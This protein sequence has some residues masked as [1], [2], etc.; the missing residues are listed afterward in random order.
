MA[1]KTRKSPSKTQTA[2]TGRSRAARRSAVVGVA[3]AIFITFAIITL[4]VYQNWPYLRHRPPF[5]WLNL[6]DDTASELRI[7]PLLAISDRPEQEPTIRF[8]DFMG[9]E[10]CAECHTSEYAAWRSSTHGTA[11][12]L[13]GKVGII[14]PFDGAPIRYRD[15]IV[16]P[17]RRDDSTY[18]FVLRRPGRPDREFTVAAVVGGGHMLGGGTQSFF[19]RFSDGTLR[20]LPFDFSK[21]SNTWFSQTR[22]SLH[23][24]PVQGNLALEDL[25]EWPPHRVLGIESTLVNCQNCHG[26]QIDLTFDPAA[27]R[28][29]T[30]FKS[31]AIDCET[32]HGPGRRHV[33]V[34]RSDRAAEQQDI[35]MHSLAALDKDRSLQVCFQCHAIKDVLQ[36]DYL[37]GRPL[38]RYFSFKMPMLAESPYHVDGRI[39]NFGYQ[40]NH[41]YSDCYLNGSMTC[42]DCHDP[43]SQKYRDIWG[44]PLPGKLDDAQCIDC[45]ASKARNLAAHTHHPAAS[46]GSRCVA[47]HMPFLQHPGI[48]NRVRF[49]RSDHT[50]AIPRPA[51][52]ASLGITGACQQCH[53]RVSVD[54]LE[55]RVRQWWGDI[56]PHPP[57]VEALHRSAPRRSR[58]LAARRLLE[59]AADH[60]MARYAALVAFIKR[61]LEPD[62]PALEPEI[63]D[64]LKRLAADADLDVRATALMA[65]HLARGQDTALRSF[66]KQAIR[67][68]APE[69]R[70]PLLDRWGMAVDYLGTEYAAAGRSQQALKA[71]RKALEVR[72]DDAVAWINLGNVYGNRGQ[73]RVAAA[74]F[75]KAAEVD[76][77][78][79]LALTNLGLALRR[80]GDTSGAIRAYE[81]AIA[82][83]PCESRAYILLA[84]LYVD[85]GQPSLA[86]DVLS[87]AR[88]QIPD[89]ETLEILAREVGALTSQGR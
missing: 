73:L 48:G 11:G 74:A 2:Q 41:L 59:P 71:H 24:I 29:R 69:E 58:L 63:V 32:C 38:E 23:W 39:R 76:P 82:R 18:V 16:E 75:Q 15:A 77:L 20:F 84:Q 34:M 42:V 21:T 85:L 10:A 81:Q 43:H 67:A 17:Q 5:A 4:L 54:S 53:A 60:P 33:E 87:V 47:C 72:P 25:S 65:L 13:P 9:A 31:L 1:R 40:Q 86:T 28:Y 70:R 7:E 19:A 56:K 44:R 45:H 12:G 8:E 88:Q 37:S 68:A 30:R 35:G 78:N 22:D 57:A 51:F 83:K 36:D 49:A 89:D 55:Q 26:S 61:Y 66:L 64:R 3:A 14:A 27:G 80:L 6:Q 79:T 62:M 52:D 50:I 46:P